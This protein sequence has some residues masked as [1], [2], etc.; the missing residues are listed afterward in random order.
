M[1][2]QPVKSHPKFKLTPEPEPEPEHKHEHEHEPGP[3]P[4]PGPESGPGLGLEHGP[5]PGPEFGHGPGPGPELG[6][7]SVPK[8]K[9]PSYKLQLHPEGIDPIPLHEKHLFSQSPI[10][11][12]FAP[13]LPKPGQQGITAIKSPNPKGQSIVGIDLGT[14]FI[15]AAVWKNGNY[16]LI[17]CT[18]D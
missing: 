17:V 10:V 8:P 5:V 18:E 2:E 7:G 3:G 6:H 4:G 9:P 11:Y 14:N 16:V 12:D 15:R 1:D 13:L